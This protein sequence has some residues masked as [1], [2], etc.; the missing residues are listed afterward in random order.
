MFIFKKLGRQERS[1]FHSMQSYKKKNNLTS[2]WF[3][4]CSFVQNSVD[5]ADQML[6]PY[7]DSSRL[8]AVW[9]ERDKEVY[10]QKFLTANILKF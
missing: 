3:D 1:I 6:V 8:V 7:Q 10:I 5:L 4:V 2:V 9:P